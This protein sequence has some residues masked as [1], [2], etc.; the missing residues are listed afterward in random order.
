M[1]LVRH[2][3]ATQKNDLHADLMSTTIAQTLVRLF[4]CPGCFKLPLAAAIRLVHPLCAIRV[5]CY[6]ICFMLLHAEYSLAA[7]HPDHETSHL[8]LMISVRRCGWSGKNHPRYQRRK[9]DVGQESMEQFHASIIVI[10]V[11][12]TLIALLTLH[13]VLRSIPS[14]EAFIMVLK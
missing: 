4:L 1:P 9:T 5:S 2:R 7:R 14:R 13:L 3:A 11:N 8:R 6:S 10:H 12:F